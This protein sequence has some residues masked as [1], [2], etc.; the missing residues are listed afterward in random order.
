[1]ENFNNAVE[2]ISNSLYEMHGKNIPEEA[3][4]LMDAIDKGYVLVEWPES[5]QFM[6]EDWFD[7]EAILS[8]GAE[9][10]TGGSAYFIPIKRIV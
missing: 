7:E 6:E 9:D 4:K 1:M 10:K 5:Q 3:N 8:L 2:I